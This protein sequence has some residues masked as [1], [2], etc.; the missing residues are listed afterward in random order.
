M[1]YS[2]MPNPSF[3]TI[4]MTRIVS[5]VCLIGF[6]SISSPNASAQDGQSGPITQVV[7]LGTGTPNADPDRSGPS[8]AIVVGDQ[9]YLVDFGP[10]VVRRAA[11][12]ARNGITGLEV[13]RLNRAFVTHLHSDHTVGF[14]DLIFTPWVLERDTPLEVYGPEGIEDMAKHIL[15]AY[16]QDINIRLFG[17]EPANNQG[18]RVEAHDVEA[19]VVYQDSLVTVEAFNVPHGS[20]P[21]AFGYRFTTP[22]RVI[23][24]SGDTAQSDIIAEMCRGCD[25]LLHEA[26]SDSAW[27]KRTPFWQ[28]YHAGFHTSATQVGEL[29]ARANPK[30]L[31]LY[32]QLEWS[33]SLDELLAE[34]KSRF[35]GN[36]VNAVDLGVY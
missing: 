1:I 29:A 33:S 11:A 34:V 30:L 31:V 35:D 10:G 16:E 13:N 28:N 3:S 24:I 20:W 26:Y 23:V 4:V 9:P 12:A 21:T 14:P 2:A 8:V 19:G 36:V 22:D 7:M 5:L 25:V 32:H 6:L 15:K 18:W 27:E 17:L